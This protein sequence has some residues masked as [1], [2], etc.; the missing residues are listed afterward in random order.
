MKLKKWKKLSS[1]LKVSNP[2]WEY[3][4]DQFE[5]EGGIRGEYR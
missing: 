1:E 4:L 5:I 2:Y 3:R